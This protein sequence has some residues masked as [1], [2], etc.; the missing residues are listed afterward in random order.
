MCRQIARIHSQ[1]KVIDAFLESSREALVLDDDMPAYAAF[2]VNRVY[3]HQIA[4]AEAM[5][6]GTG[7]QER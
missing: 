2:L 1:V 4:A 7:E 3:W 5:K 6:G